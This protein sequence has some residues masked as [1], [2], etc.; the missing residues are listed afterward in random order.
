MNLSF[1]GYPSRRRSNLGIVLSHSL[2]INIV[3]LFCLSSVAGLYSFPIERQALFPFSQFY[4]LLQTTIFTI[5]S[6][7]LNVNK[8]P[9]T[10]VYIIRF[11]LCLWN[12][13]C[14]LPLLLL[15]YEY[16]GG[17]AM[18]SSSSESERFVAPRP[19]PCRAG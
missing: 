9:A 11:F 3:S 10:H 14:L 16:G 15:R 17:L 2:I 12:S 8:S 4:L 19:L 6:A 18:N 7:R 5:S 1:H 13:V